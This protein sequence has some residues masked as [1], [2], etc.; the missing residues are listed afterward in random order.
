MIPGHT[1]QAKESSRSESLP[2]ALDL[3][4][5]C[6]IL[7]TY[8][9]PRFPSGKLPGAGFLGEMIRSLES[10]VATASPR[11]HMRRRKTWE[12]QVRDSRGISQVGNCQGRF[13]GEKTTS[14][15]VPSR[16]REPVPSIRND[17]EPGG[18]T[19]ETHPCLPAWDQEPHLARARQS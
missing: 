6:A 10:P 8:T 17:D 9:H 13:L 18:L 16:R 14:L 5:W 19:R 4:L 1:S 2:A 15:E 11:P 3:L 7:F 12:P